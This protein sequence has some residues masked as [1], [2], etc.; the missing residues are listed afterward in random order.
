M[1]RSEIFLWVLYILGGYLLGGVMF[2][3]LVPRALCRRDI[4]R[5]SEDGN[6]GVY[7]VFVLC[8]KKLG[9][10]CLLLELGKGFLPVW[11]ACRRLPMDNLLFALV[12][13]A[14]VLGHA[15]APFDRDIRG[16]KAIAA[17]FGSLLGCVPHCL[18]VLW[19]AALYISFSTFVRV[20]SHRKRSIL[21]FAF[22]ALGAC[23]GLLYAGKP[24]FALG[25]AA[26]ALV[27]I[28]RHVASP[29]DEPAKAKAAV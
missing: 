2:A 8:G 13:A 16:G 15:T 26:I 11:A 7:N 29:D 23:A 9:T 1:T 18:A 4:C 5:E 14:P 19:L 10:I 25:C 20:P 22:F 28:V 6:P 24:A 21:T 17:T 3:R 27:V 12:L